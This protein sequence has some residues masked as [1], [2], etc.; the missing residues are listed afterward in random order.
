[1]RDSAALLHG[2]LQ[3]RC[4]S[5]LATLFF[6]ILCISAFFSARLLDVRVI[7]SV[8]TNLVHDFLTSGSFH[9]F[10]FFKRETDPARH[11]KLFLMFSKLVRVESVQY[12]TKRKSDPCSLFW[13]NT[14]SLP[15]GWRR[16][17]ARRRNLAK[18][19]PK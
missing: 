16:W 19:F 15:F 9:S 7:I 3:R 14:H 12:S 6:F 13:D 5:Y 1:M 10:F 11:F 8:L 2:I 17:I 4:V 18:K